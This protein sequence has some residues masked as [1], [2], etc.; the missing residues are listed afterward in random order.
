MTSRRARVSPYQASAGSRSGAAG[1]P[2][3]PLLEE[4]LALL[5]AELLDAELLALLEAE[6]LALLEAEPPAPLE[7]VVVTGGRGSSPP[8]CTRATATGMASRPRGVF[9]SVC[10]T[11]ISSSPSSAAARGG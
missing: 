5:D 4:P 3:V 1:A 8:Q 6:P 9:F 11:R 2:P 10:K 7:E